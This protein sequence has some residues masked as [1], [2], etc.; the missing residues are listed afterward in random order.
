MNGMWSVTSRS[1]PAPTLTT[2]I[3]KSGAVR[4]PQSKEACLMT[5][6]LTLTRT[7]LTGMRCTAVFS[8]CEQ[9]RY[10]LV[11]QWDDS[12]P[13]LTFW[14]LNPSTATHEELDNTVKGLI[15]RAR[16]WGYGGVRVINLFGFRATDPADMKKQ[17]DPVGPDN[18]RV[19]AQALQDAFETGVPII[20]GW[21]AH[22]SHRDRDT[23]CRLMAI[24]RDVRTMFLELNADG[25][26]KHPL[27]I[28][29]DL[30]PTIWE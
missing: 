23:E 14:L 25:S 20:C 28:K 29:H 21:G 16:H 7:D 9:Y 1:S 4:W 19:I 18:D 10:D 22:G 15:K 30:R 13:L 17:D 27:Y 8:P 5:D 11:W 6:L 12:K 26:P 3:Q 2:T 24:D